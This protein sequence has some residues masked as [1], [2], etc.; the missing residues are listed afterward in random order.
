[1]NID[2]LKISELTASTKVSENSVF[3]S[4]IET[5]SPLTNRVKIPAIRSA[6]NF[7][8]AFNDTATGVLETKDGDAF[9]TYGNADKDFVLG[10]R[11]NGGNATELTDDSGAQLRYIGKQG[12]DR[13][14]L[15]LDNGITY[16]TPETYTTNS[17]YGSIED[18]LNA[19][20]AAAKSSGLPVYCANKYTITN[21]TKPLY[22][23]GIKVMGGN[24]TGTGGHNVWASN[25][26]F[27]GVT[28]AGVAWRHNGGDVAISHCTFKN[29]TGIQAVSLK[30]LPAV[31]TIII[32]NCH[33]ENN[34]YGIL[35]DGSKGSAMTRTIIRDNTFYNHKGDPIEMNLVQIDQPGY[36]VISGN[37]IDTVN[38]T[39]AAWGIGIG[40]AGAGNYA[41][42]SA[43]TDMAANIIVRDNLV[44]NCR[45][46]I[47]FEKS[48][49]F[50][51]TNN[52]VYP[53]ANYSP[54]ATTGLSAAGLVFYGCR[55]FFLEGNSA[56]P[57]T[58]VEETLSLRWGVTGG[59][60]SA[61]CRNFVIR[62]MES[63]GTT[64]IYNG[65]TDSVDS[66]IV[67][68]DCRFANFTMKGY[69][70]SA[71]LSNITAVGTAHT[72]EVAHTVGE[73]VGILRRLK[74]ISLDMHNV[75]LYS[76]AMT[77]LGTVGSLY[78]DRLHA[79]N[80][81]FTA[82]KMAESTNGR[83]NLTQPVTNH[84]Y[85][86]NTALTNGEAMPIGEEFIAGTM[87]TLTGTGTKW[88]ITTGGSF[89]ATTSTGSVSN[90]TI[91]ATVV[92]QTYIESANLNWLGAYASKSAGL[93][94]IVPGAGV[95]GADLIVTAVRA[96][97]VGNSYY[98]IDIEEPIVTATASG[99]II[100]PAVTAIAV[101]L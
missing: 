70:S 39:N 30:E 42:Q 33:F 74:R 77:P 11:R 16:L 91:R 35:R 44:I 46:C 63:A 10:W 13:I 101:K 98:R 56:F 37:F 73:G 23:D 4:V 28:F 7:E 86:A 100:R 90:D 52:Y 8:N 54:P 3:P 36:I 76:K 82:L 2:L 17:I 29:S 78:V 87:L 14:K 94:L 9:F 83:G 41:L 53:N 50:H 84:V 88:L 26:T 67:I 58:G 72:I 57:A 25:C 15:K 1:M 95:S 55:D 96:A 48:R 38:G 64:I 6:I 60:Y 51:V 45:H 75:K 80:C 65:A 81:N 22:L 47:H 59:V 21:P 92:G 20:F 85:F 79:T 43:D 99:T 93:K 49:A 40:V 69:F 12:V 24:F 34:N 27:S 62:G 97:Y 19:C 61:P 89:P 5:G 71:R 32:E 18:A 66:N 68:E 31:G